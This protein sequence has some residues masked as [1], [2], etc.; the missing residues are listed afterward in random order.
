MNGQLTPGQTVLNRQTNRRM[1]FLGVEDYGD[2]ELLLL[3][4]AKGDPERKQWLRTGSAV[5]WRR[6]WV[7][8]PGEQIE[9]YFNS[10]G[11]VSSCR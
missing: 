8:L 9:F 2:G 5:L 4:P 6:D 11:G 7:W 10:V 1:E 3:R